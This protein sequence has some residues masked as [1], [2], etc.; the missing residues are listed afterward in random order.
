MTDSGYR[1]FFLPISFI[2]F[3]NGERLLKQSSTRI[4]F[5][6]LYIPISMNM[7]GIP[8]KSLS[9]P[10]RP[11]ESTARCY[12]SIRYVR[13]GKRMT[14]QRAERHCLPEEGLKLRFHQDRKG[15]LW[16]RCRNCT[17]LSE[18]GHK[19][20]RKINRKKIRLIFCT[21]LHII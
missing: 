8:P 1:Y 16:L 15:F 17:R 14:L 3:Q 5:S 7:S 13:T 21:F 11:A 10:R 12:M 18:N 6:G 19:N 9:M 20:N 2:F 4:L